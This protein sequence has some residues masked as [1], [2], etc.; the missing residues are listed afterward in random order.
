MGQNFCDFINSYRV[1]E[2]KKILLKKNNLSIEGIG[3][4]VGFKAKTTFYTSFKKFTGKPPTK[5]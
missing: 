1:E 4:E 2:A 5:Y 3:Y